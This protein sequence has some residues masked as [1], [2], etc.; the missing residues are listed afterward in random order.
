[1]CV[2]SAVSGYCLCQNR[3]DRWK[4]Y[5]CQLRGTQL[6]I[7]NVKNGTGEATRIKTV[8]DIRFV[9]FNPLTLPEKE[10]ITGGNL[11]TDCTERFRVFNQH[12]TRVF[13]PASASDFERWSSALHSVLETHLDN[14]DLENRRRIAA[15]V[16]P[17]YQRQQEYE[18]KKASV[19]LHALSNVGFMEKEKKNCV[20]QGGNTRVVCG[21][22]CCCA[23]TDWFDV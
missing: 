16:E 17:L 6:V 5:F 10:A 3:F 7:K 8:M 2:C 15:E 11:S 13:V 21:S 23:S 20:R 22:V 1:M 12:R 14:D 19:I 9:T 4:R 18:A